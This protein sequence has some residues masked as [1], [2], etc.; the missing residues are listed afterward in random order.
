[1]FIN[2]V[3]LGLNIALFYAHL[4]LTVVIKRICYVMLCYDLWRHRRL[5][6]ARRGSVIVTQA[7]S[8]VFIQD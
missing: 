1:M 2:F 7:I 5:Y 4:R 8:S 6:V 3:L